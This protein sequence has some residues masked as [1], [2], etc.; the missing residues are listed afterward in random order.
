MY[1]HILVPVDSSACSAAAA[2]H[3]HRLS[4]LL[5]SK[6]TL[7]HVL[8]DTPL[9]RD[10]ARANAQCL[11]EQLSVGARF[12]P[13]TLLVEANGRTVCDVVIEVAMETGAELIMVGSHGRSGIE[14]MVLGSV[15]QS[16][17]SR[18]RVPVEIIPVTGADASRIGE[19]WRRATNTEVPP[20]KDSK[21]PAIAPGTD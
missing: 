13:T 2:Q 20:R 7:M 18:A 8:S 15:A 11:L 9:D 10:A 17:A 16:I 19:R 14:R 12:A 6:V 1:R 21:V 5:G 3:A 4:R